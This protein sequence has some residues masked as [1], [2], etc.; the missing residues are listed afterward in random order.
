MHDVDTLLA[1]VA[2]QPQHRGERLPALEAMPHASVSNWD[3]HAADGVE[4][5]ALAGETVQRRIETVAIEQAQHLDE[6]GL[7]AAHRHRLDRINDA[8][9]LHTLT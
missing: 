9:P 3:I 7:A 6:V 2:R 8:N 1:Q 4:Q 5:D